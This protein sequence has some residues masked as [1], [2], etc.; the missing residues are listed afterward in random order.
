MKEDIKR[1]V[2][3]CPTCQKTKHRKQKYG[4]LPTKK[5]EV[6]PWDQLCID[7]VG[8]YK[9]PIN[10]SKKPYKKKEFRELWCVTMI[11]PATSWFE[12]AEIDNKTPMGIANIVEQTWLCR[13]PWPRIITF[14]R[15]TE[16]MAGFTKCIK[17]EYNIKV[18]PTTV[19]NPHANSILERIH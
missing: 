1:F 17:E 18:K 16:F 7:C 15:G 9:I 19:R 8:P 13:Y 4:Y 6:T 3:K 14:D 5:A 10:S 2:T 11:D 12:M